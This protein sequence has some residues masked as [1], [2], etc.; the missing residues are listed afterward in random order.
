MD[1]ELFIRSLKLALKDPDIKNDFGSIVADQLQVLRLELNEKD[2]TIRKLT[3]RVASLESQ[4][5]GQEQYSRRN[6][7]TI[8]GIQEQPDEIIIDKTL[9]LFNNKMA[10]QPQISPEDIDRTHRIGKE[11]AN[12]GSRQ[13]I[14]KFT[15]YRARERVVSA[16]TTLR[17]STVQLQDAVFIN[18]ALTPQRSKILYQL[19]KMKKDGEIKKVW[20]N[21][22]TFVVIDNHNTKKSAKTLI[23]ANKLIK[24]LKPSE[25]ESDE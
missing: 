11:D 6:C 25:T 10:V 4:L 12:R 9:H 13:V 1:P 20:T 2:E 17:S 21:D 19:R 22:G 24:T 18:E 15:S 8:S 16:R 5:E 7:I 14:V 3:S 23:E